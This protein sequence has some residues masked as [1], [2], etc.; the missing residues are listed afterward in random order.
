MIFTEP[1]EE[2]IAY[3]KNVLV[4]EEIEEGLENV[5]LKDMQIVL[6]RPCD[7][8]SIDLLN[9][10]INSLPMVECPSI[11]LDSI[12]SLVKLF[13]PI[14][15]RAFKGLILLYTEYGVSIPEIYAL[16]YALLTEEMFEIEGD[17]LV[18]LL[19]DLLYSD[20]LSMQTVRE[21]L[22]RLSYIAI[23][24][25]ISIAYKIL[26]V[27]SVITHKHRNI[28]SKIPK[29]ERSDTPLIK[30]LR[31]IP[32]ADKNQLDRSIKQAGPY[33][34]DAHH[35]A[36]DAPH[37]TALSVNNETEDYYL[38]ELDVLKDHP[39]L[40]AYI[41]DIKQNRVLNI[42]EEEINRKVLELLQ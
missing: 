3:W 11:A 34:I 27:I 2:R 35:T 18:I 23:R 28:I 13:S 40:N 26:N 15:V 12:V 6:D 32:K 39:I 14:S 21:F 7:S 10:L 33:E 37:H 22:K 4:D 1:I 25:H 41:R 24:M 8:L 29:K 17:L 16:L 20:S 30:P 38:Y 19:N 5:L 36:Q 42:K 31:Q 9:L